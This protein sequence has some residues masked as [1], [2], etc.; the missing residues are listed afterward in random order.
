MTATVEG[1]G[2]FVAETCAYRRPVF[3]CEVDVGGEGNVN[4]GLTSVH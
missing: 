4:V 2:V 1:A 3:A